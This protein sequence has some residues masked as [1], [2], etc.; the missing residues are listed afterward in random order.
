MK[1]FFELCGV[2]FRLNCCTVISLLG[3]TLATVFIAPFAIA[4][5]ALIVGACAMVAVVA[6]VLIVAAIVY[7]SFTATNSFLFK[8]LYSS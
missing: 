7:Y 4:I 3:A 6:I 5:F 2:Y 1:R 8:L